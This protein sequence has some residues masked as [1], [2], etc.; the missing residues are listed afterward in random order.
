MLFKLFHYTRALKLRLSLFLEVKKAKREGKYLIKNSY[1]RIW[2]DPQIHQDY[3]WL[4]RFIDKD[5]DVRLIDIGGNSGYW[6]ELFKEY[7][8][9]K[10]T[11]AFEPVEEM[12]N[13]YKER[14]I[15]DKSVIVFKFAVGEKSEKLEINVEANF[16]LTSF[17]YYNN[18]KKNKN[19]LFIRKEM[20]EIKPLNFFLDEIFKP[21]EKL[22]T[23]LKIDVQ[24]FEDNVLKGAIKILPKVDILILECS[25][26]NEFK[27]KN[28][29]FGFCAGL[30]NEFDL[31]PVQFGTY[32]HYN[33]PIANERNVFFVK[34][35]LLTKIWGY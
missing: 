11:I 17:N 3:I 7:F 18:P 14:Y 8:S 1:R 16:T 32:N 2:K 25:F 4:Y 35:S 15:D 12:Y 19:K 6:S 28:P 31:F 13:A 10:K 30:L 27:D 22:T 26:F 23:V 21:E 5:E 24:G 9:T 33:G 34:K 29:T 20:V